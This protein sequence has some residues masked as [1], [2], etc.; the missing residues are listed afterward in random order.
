MWIAIGTLVL[1]C[2]GCVGL[3]GLASNTSS[4]KTATTGP[5]A[6]KP[7]PS[8]QPAAQT[9]AAPPENDV[10]PAGSAVRD[11]QFEFV[12]TNVEQ[13]TTR[14]GGRFWGE[15]AKGEFVLVSVD[16]SNVGKRA[17]TYFGSDQVLIDDQN[18]EFEA[19][20]SANSA[21]NDYGSHE[22]LNPG[23]KVSVV[24]A[25]DVPVGVVPVAIEFHDSMFSGGARVALR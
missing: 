22:D 11:G 20:F 25:F 19:S 15:E 10:A 6:A 18:R 2:G 24:I 5:V 14:V 1:S 4:T 8:E 17:Q 21:L 9:P 23:H 13:G 16:I 12:I 7:S 3:I